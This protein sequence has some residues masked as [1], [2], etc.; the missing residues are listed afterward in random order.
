[1]AEPASYQG[2]SAFLRWWPPAILVLA[3]ITIA[4][5]GMAGLRWASVFL[6]A[7]YL[8]HR[9]LPWQFTVLADGVLLAFPFG[10][11]MFVPKA[12]MQV[13]ME[14]VGATA[15]TDGHRR[16]GYPL[17]DSILYVPGRTLLMQTAFAGFGYS[18]ARGDGS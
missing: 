4:A 10:R 9:F 16:F 8:H 11:R 18:F 17:L 1:V 13:R 14:A 15:L 7:A 3:A 12:E 2:G 5:G 6:L